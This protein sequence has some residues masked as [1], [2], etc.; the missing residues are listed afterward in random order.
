MAWKHGRDLWAHI[1]LPNGT[2]KRCSLHTNDKL[3]AKA[4]EGMAAQLCGRRDPLLEAAVTGPLNLGILYDHWLRGENGLEELRSRL[5]DVDL[6]SYVASWQQWLSRRVDIGTATKYLAQ[7]RVL[8]PEEQRFPISLFSRRALSVK[9]AELDCTGSTARRYHAAWSSFGSFLVERDVIE[10]NPLRHVGAPRANPPRE[11]FLELNDVVRLVDAQPEPF[12]TLS[13]LREGSGMEISAALKVLRGDFNFANNTSRARGTKNKWRDRTVS[14]EPWAMVRIAEFVKANGLTPAA[15]LFPNVSGARALDVL[16]S[17]LAALNLPAGY[18]LHDARHSFAVRWMKRG[19]P[20]Q[21]I[22]NNLG[23]K[24]A[25]QVLKIY[26]KYRPTLL[27]M[28]EAANW[29]MK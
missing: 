9:L 11:L 16:R 3:V 4:I 7:L 1:R 10:W 24:D 2:K 13:A 12:R 25:S 8:I 18:T 26:G 20:P 6:N 28:S 17:A 5:S 21:L 15:P 27:D 22:A 14:V 23:H 29:G 19:V